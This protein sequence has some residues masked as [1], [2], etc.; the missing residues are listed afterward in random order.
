MKEGKGSM[1]G[2]V[3]GGGNRSEVGMRKLG[4]DGIA[5]DGLSNACG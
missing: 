3:G 5:H 4:T 1:V 2:F